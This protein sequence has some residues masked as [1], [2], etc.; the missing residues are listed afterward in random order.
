M[1]TYQNPII[2]ITDFA[3]VTMLCASTPE[4]LGVSYSPMGGITGD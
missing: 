1:K 4:T 2:S 3:A